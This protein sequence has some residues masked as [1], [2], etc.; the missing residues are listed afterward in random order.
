MKEG[1]DS[2]V[3]VASVKVGRDSSVDVASVKVGRDSSVGR[4]SVKEGRDSSVGRVSVKEGR[5]SSV[6]R[7]SVKE[8]GIAHLVWRRTKKPGAIPTRVRFYNTRGMFPPSE[9]TF[10]ADSLAVFVQPP[11]TIACISICA[12]VKNPKHW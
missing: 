2:S 1:R 8:G 11:C 3:G 7:V 6:G 4:V 12:S 5:D 9:S 10:S